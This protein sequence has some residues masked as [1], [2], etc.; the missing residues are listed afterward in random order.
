MRERK[1]FC[2]CHGTNVEMHQ[3]TLLWPVLKNEHIVTSPLLHVNIL[4]NSLEGSVQMYYSGSSFTTR[5]DL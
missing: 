5:E 2:V 4:W 1:Y 3:P